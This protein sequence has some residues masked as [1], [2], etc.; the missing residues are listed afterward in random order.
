MTDSKRPA[1]DDWRRQG[2]EY[3]SGARWVFR[4]YRPYRSDWEHDHCVLCSAKLSCDEVDLNEGYATED[5][6]HWVCAECFA[7]FRD[8]LG[9]SVDQDPP[10]SG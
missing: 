6:Y 4:A 9:W 10:A 5:E 2:Q 7:D 3:L 8:E 1:A